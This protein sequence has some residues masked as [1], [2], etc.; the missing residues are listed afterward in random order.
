LK[1]WVTDDGKLLHCRICKCEEFEVVGRGEH[2]SWYN[3]KCNEGHLMTVREELLLFD[4][5]K[6]KKMT[7]VEEEDDVC[8]VEHTLT[9]TYEKRITIFLP[10][11]ED[12]EDY[13]PEVEDRFDWDD[14]DTVMHDTR[15]TSKVLPWKAVYDAK[16][17]LDL[18]KFD[19]LRG[20][21][22]GEPKKVKSA[23]VVILPTAQK[24]LY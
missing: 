6:K 11:G 16:G 15:S 9:R 2:G 22:K 17:R 12:P 19:V 7:L 3:M 14:V 4:G 21:V 8:I 23:Q 10:D 20:K 24:T 13:L 18:N 5:K 1:F